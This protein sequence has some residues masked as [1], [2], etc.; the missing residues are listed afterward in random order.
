MSER[1]YL[2]YNCF[3]R[4]FDDRRQARIRLEAD[5]CEEIFDQAE[6]GEIELVWSFMHDDEN[7]VCPFPDR[8]AEVQTLASICALRIA[9]DDSVTAAAKEFVS[10]GKLS[11]K[12]A[13][14][15]AAALH[16]QAA[17]F[18][19]CDDQL[20]KR[21]ARLPIALQVVDPVQYVMRRAEDNERDTDVDG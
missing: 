16:A 13:L 6:A 14:H 19:T 12:D 11:G 17:W 15:L 20:R 21:A 18:V 1:V 9:P 5:A 8:K 4:G 3:Q 2:D 7:I 10:E